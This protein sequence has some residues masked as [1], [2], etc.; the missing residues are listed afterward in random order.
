MSV[1]VFGSLA[2]VAL[3][4]SAFACELPPLVVI[5]PRV[6]DGNEA[7]AVRKATNAYFEGMTG[8]VACI[9]AELAAAGG[10]AAPALVK[11]AVVARNNA[12]VAEA[13][14]VKKTFE[15]NGYGGRDARERGRAAQTDRRHCERYARLR[16]HDTGDGRCHAAAACSLA[17]RG[18]RRGLDPRRI[19]Y[20]GVDDR[21]WDVYDVR[22]EK[23]STL[24]HIA[25]VA[26]GKVG[27]ALVL[28]SP[29]ELVTRPQ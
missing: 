25:L 22:L 5:T 7:P 9:Q 27:G 24:W 21:D 14:A 26:D 10:A 3:A 20:S 28:R 16:G 29:T 19:A 8:Y 18:S 1:A 23:F 4:S 2:F 15:A 13:E 17:E 12:A 6:L 11:A